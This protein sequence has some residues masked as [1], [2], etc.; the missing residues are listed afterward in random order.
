MSWPDSTTIVLVSACHRVSYAE[1][2]SKFIGTLPKLFLWEKIVYSPLGR[3]RS[4]APSAMARCSRR[5]S[6][7]HGGCGSQ[8]RETRV[9]PSVAKCT[10]T[11]VLKMYQGQFWANFRR[12]DA[13]KG[14]APAVDVR[15]LLAGWGSAPHR[16]PEYKASC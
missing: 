3:G 14:S 4:C 1:R 9:L 6:W 7:P 11:N 13:E 15:P 5:L 8:R 16:P 10:K 2:Y 12:G